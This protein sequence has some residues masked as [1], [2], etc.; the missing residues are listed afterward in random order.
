MKVCVVTVT[1]GNRFYLLEKLLNILLDIDVSEII[2]VSN[3]SSEDSKKSLKEYLHKYRKCVNLVELPRNTGS[4]GGFKIGIENFLKGNCDFIWLLDDDNL[5]KSDS[6]EI[7]KKYWKKLVEP[8]K[9]QK[10]ALLANRVDRQNFNK[11]LYTQKSTHV[12]PRKNNFMGF[13]WADMFEKVYERLFKRNLYQNNPRCVYT[14]VSVA[15][16]GGLFFHKSLLHRIDLPQEKYVLYMDDF[17]FTLPI[18][19]NGGTI[20][21]IAESILEDAEQSS[22]LPKRK[23]W[24]HHTLFETKTQYAYYALRNIL[25]FCKNYLTDNFLVFKINQYSFYLFITV[26][27]L[28]RGKL[29][30]L[31]VL[32]DAIRDAA[33]DKMGLNNNYRL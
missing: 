29:S 11:V 7:L 33:D 24:L 31:K 18:T 3:G 10:I 2:I 17:A 25:Y 4:A 8:T 20:Y 14:Q 28:I 21:L 27:A 5:P 15:P 6:L 16:Y 13:H 19:T 30:R 12:L 9:Y 22:Y 32:R 23:K 26:M 1:Y